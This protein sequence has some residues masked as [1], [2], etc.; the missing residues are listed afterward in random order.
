MVMGEIMEGPIEQQQ[1]PYYDVFISYRYRDSALAKRLEETILEYGHVPFREENFREL[2]DRRDVTKKTVE[3]IRTNLSK[4]TCL[5]F[6]YSRKSA[7]AAQQHNDVVG[8][9]MPWELG[10]FDGSVSGRIGVY[11]LDGPP[12]DFYSDD[13]DAQ[14]YFRGSEYLQ[15]YE[16]LTADNLQAFLARNAVRERRIDNVASAFVWMRNL[17]EESIVNP[18]NVGLGIA[19]WYVDHL[20]RYHKSVGNVLG[21]AFYD[22]L[23]VQMDDL[24]V[25]WSPLFRWKLGS[26]ILGH[27]APLGAGGVNFSGLTSNYTKMFG[28]WMA[29]YMRTVNVEEVTASSAPLDRNKLNTTN[30]RVAMEAFEKNVE[31]AIEMYSKQNLIDLMPPASEVP[32]T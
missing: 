2:L 18:L 6:A 11:L 9:W 8:V 17:V 20:A 31:Q 26:A 27:P 12:D 5:I 16:F 13:F 22:S 3:I 19:E 30:S 14:E 25:D 4:A 15:I 21:G 23:K 32:R 7:A 1:R 29:E 24:R 10:F 28:E